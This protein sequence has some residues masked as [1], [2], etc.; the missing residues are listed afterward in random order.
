GD[1]A[2]GCVI[3]YGR[4]EKDVERLKTLQTDVLGIFGTQD[5]GIPPSMVAEFEENMEAANQSLS[6]HNYDAGHGFANPSNPNHVEEAAEEAWELTL[7]FLS[8]RL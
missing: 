4:P 5:K 6:V 1:Q 8:R 2:A 3:Y 7:N